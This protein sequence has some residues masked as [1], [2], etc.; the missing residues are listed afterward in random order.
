MV[1]EK[2]KKISAFDY[3]RRFFKTKE[4]LLSYPTASPSAKEM[5]NKTNNEGEITS[6]QRGVLEEKDF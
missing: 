2:K 1:G 6:M 5:V 4:F 3:L